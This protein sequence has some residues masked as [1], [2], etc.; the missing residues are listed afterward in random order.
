[1]LQLVREAWREDGEWVGVS[2]TD[3]PST[4]LRAQHLV[5]R[6]PDNYSDW[7]KSTVIDNLKEVIRLLGRYKF[8][9]LQIWPV[10]D[11]EL[12]S[13]PDLWSGLWSQSEVSELVDAGHDHEVTLYPEVKTIGKFFQK[14]GTEN[15]NE[16]HAEANELLEPYEEGGGVPTEFPEPTSWRLYEDDVFDIVTDVVDELYDLFDQP[17]YIHMGGD[18]ANHIGNSLDD[19]DPGDLYATYANDMAD[20]IKNT[21]GATPMLWHDMLVTEDNF[22]DY[23]SAH[24]GPPKNTASGR[25]QLDTDIEMC[26]WNYGWP[27]DD[28]TVPT[29]YPMVETFQN[30]GFTV[31]GA[32]WHRHDNIANLTCRCGWER[33]VGGM[34]QT[35]WNIHDSFHLAQGK[36]FDS[37]DRKDDVRA[38]RELGVFALL[39]EAAWSPL[40]AHDPMSSYSPLL[41]VAADLPFLDMQTAKD[42][43]DI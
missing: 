1:V 12:D 27:T 31:N 28:G 40:G 38:R 25:Q 43:F 20:H 34:I 17:E 2:L 37:Q 22:P 32:T 42:A 30:E 26:V 39:S 33:G 24:G 21:H 9:H 36:S 35:A 13:H 15:P 6:P 16:L 41:R 14:V 29:E 3:Y 8:T 7:S 11:I 23:P 4:R 10:A 5:L 18:E 19:D